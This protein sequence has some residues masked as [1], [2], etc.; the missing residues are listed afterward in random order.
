[1][2]GEELTCDG[3]ILGGE[4]CFGCCSIVIFRVQDLLD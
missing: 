2:L 4:E 1:M 3:E